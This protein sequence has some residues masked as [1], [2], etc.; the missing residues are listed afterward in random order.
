MQRN[1]LNYRFWSAISV[2]L[3]VLCIS[4]FYYLYTDE[5]EK[6]IDE[7][8]ARQLVHAK[9][10]AK[11]LENY[12]DSWIKQLSIIARNES[13]IKLKP[14]GK[15]FIDSFYEEQKEH[16]KS[17]LRVDTK[18]TIVY[19]PSYLKITGKNIA[20]EKHI[21]EILKNKKAI[22]SDI[23]MA[24]QGYNAIAIHVPVFDGRKFVGTLGSIIQ[25][26]A[27]GKRFL[28]D[29]IIGESGYAWMISKDGTELYCPVPGHQGIRFLKPAKNSLL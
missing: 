18:G 7:L 21:S 9:Q 8:N 1:R 22:V 28:E 12:I 20:W 15:K 6:T 25:V 5:K 3:F 27:A 17:L 11:G 19:A 4:L 14:S 26:E 23:F 29:I 2:V 10:A 24:V 13:V 16:I